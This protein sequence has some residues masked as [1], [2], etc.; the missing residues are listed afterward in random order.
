MS[1]RKFYEKV[2][3]VE[4]GFPIKFTKSSGFFHTH[5]HEYIELLYFLS[6]GE[7]FCNGKN[8]DMKSGELAVINS[9]E[10][11]STIEGSFYCMRIA[12]SFFSDLNTSDVYFINHIPCDSVI[13]DC[14]ER[15]YS[16]HNSKELGYDMEIK[17][18]AYHLIRHLCVNYASKDKSKSVM[19]DMVIEALGFIADNYTEKLSTS[20]ICTHLH[21]SENY[22]SHTFKNAMGFT[23]VEYINKYRIEKAAEL[24][25]TTGKSVTEISASVGISD[26]NYFSRL[27]KRYF[28]ISP[29]EYRKNNI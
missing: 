27:F 26:T 4:K 22:F 1:N 7:I 12:P 5:W 9:T 20:D 17:S 21:M 19:V 8:L 3:P 14:F 15:I 10:L 18:Q 11:H 16:E 6:E 28:D 23:P 29:R 13:K 25:A 2:I 24:L